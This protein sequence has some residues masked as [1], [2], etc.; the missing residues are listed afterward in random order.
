[1]SQEEMMMK[2]LTASPKTIG[3]VAEILDGRLAETTPS[4]RRL[5]TLTEAAHELALSR[6]TIHR[7]CADGRLATIQTRAGRRRIASAELTAFL[8]GKGVS[9]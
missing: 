5:L 8:Q 7:M 3:R 6:M 9:A 2:L 4:D 1:M